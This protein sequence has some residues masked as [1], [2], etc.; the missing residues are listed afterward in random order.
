MYNWFAELPLYMPI[1][2]AVVGGI[3]LYSVGNEK[4]FRIISS[5]LILLAVLGFLVSQLLESDREIVERKTKEM[6]SSVSSAQWDRLPTYFHPKAHILAFSD[7]DSIVQAIKSNC[8]RINLRSAR[9]TSS[10]SVQE[11]D[12]WTVSFN[13]NA[14]AESFSNIQTQWEAT[15]IK[16]QD[17]WVIS[18]IRPLGGF[19]VTADDLAGW[20]RSKF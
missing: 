16:D 17:Q 13:V 2:A 12:Q 10:K 14:E 4:K 7:R 8:E 19:G 6:V 11:G 1:A 3:L 20:I 5:C 18:E 15:W 9:Q